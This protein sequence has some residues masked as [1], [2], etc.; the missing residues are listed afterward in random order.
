MQQHCIKQRWLRSG[1]R[2]RLAA[3]GQAG[4]QDAA[5][6]GL[7]HIPNELS[8][9]P[10]QAIGPGLAHR[11]CRYCCPSLRHVCSR[12]PR[13]LPWLPVLQIFK[14]SYGKVRGA[15]PCLQHP[16]ACHRRCQL[17]PGFDMAAALLPMPYPPSS[18]FLC[19][20]A[21]G[22]AAEVPPLQPLLAAAAAAADAH[23]LP[24][25]LAAC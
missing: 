7:F 8:H 22:A 24:A 10:H 3:N 12:A 6:Q 16:S 17:P 11:C 25:R 5:R 9:L 2:R 14:G 1:A 15:H 21:A 19:F 23:P 13:S 4:P 20:C 18:S